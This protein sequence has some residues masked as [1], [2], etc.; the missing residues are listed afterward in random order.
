MC[1]EPI[2]FK[3]GPN[4]VYTNSEHIFHPADYPEQD[5]QFDFDKDVYPVVIQC[6][7][8]EGD[9]MYKNKYFAFVKKSIFLLLLFYRTSSIA[10]YYGKCG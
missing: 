5:L 2:K 8:L 3:G 1:S 7:A 4:Q 10:Y 9:G 6:I